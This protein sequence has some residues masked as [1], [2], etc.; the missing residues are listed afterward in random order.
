MKG[1]VTKTF[2]FDS[3]VHERPILHTRTLHDYYEFLLFEKCMFWMLLCPLANAIPCSILKSDFKIKRICFCGILISSGNDTIYINCPWYAKDL[4]GTECFS[5][6]TPFKLR[7]HCIFRIL[8]RAVRVFWHRFA[9]SLS[10]WSLILLLLVM[11]FYHRCTRS[12][13]GGEGKISGETES[14]RMAVWLRGEVRPQVW[15]WAGCQFG[16]GGGKA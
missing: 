15:G 8:F 10:I 11:L 12:A 14:G 6:V 9:T 5:D 3:F 4:S 16:K 2:L 1:P 13:C 7:D